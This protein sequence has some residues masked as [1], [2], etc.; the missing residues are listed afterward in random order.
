MA[1]SEFSG[2]GSADA[3]DFVDFRPRFGV[4]SAVVIACCC[5][6]PVVVRRVAFIIVGDCS[7][8]AV[9]ED[10]A[11]RRVLIVGAVCG[12]A[13]LLKQRTIHSNRSIDSNLFFGITTD[14]GVVLFRF[15]PKDFGVSTIA[16][17][18]S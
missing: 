3:T 16:S 15:R 1:E 8:A 5:C 12:V 14:T 18:S 2:V 7:I 13:G 9:V 17:I 11:F 6:A 10:V 4:I